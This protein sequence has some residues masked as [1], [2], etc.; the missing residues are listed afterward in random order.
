MS[1]G[2]NSTHPEIW[3][4]PLTTEK[5]TPK[6]DSWRML[7]ERNYWYGTLLKKRTIEISSKVWSSEVPNSHFEVCLL[8]TSTV[9][10]FAVSAFSN[11]WPF[12]NSELFAT[13]T[14]QNLT[15]C[16]SFRCAKGDGHVIGKGDVQHVHRIS[17]KRK[18]WSL[19]GPRCNG[20][21]SLLSQRKIRAVTTIFL[22]LSVQPCQNSPVAPREPF[23]IWSKWSHSVRCQLKTPIQVT[24]SSGSESILY[25]GQ[26][27]PPCPIKT[28]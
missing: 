18:Q 20:I 23:E 13:Q 28:N 4:E 14:Q 8:S 27:C 12:S 17:N 7:I 5:F 9:S 10:H 25:Y 19:W 3:R 2:F 22:F 24:A 1:D 15:S 26:S 16:F 6:D 11:F 21:W